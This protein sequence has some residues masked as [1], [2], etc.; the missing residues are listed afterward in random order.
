MKF[1]AITLGFVLFFAGCDKYV[2]RSKYDGLQKQLEETK[3]QLEGVQRQLNEGR[4][5]KF[6]TFSQGP[7]TWRFDPTTGE[8]CLL[9]NIEADWK[10]KATKAESCDCKDAWRELQKEQRKL[11]TP[12]ERKRYWEGTKPFIDMFCGT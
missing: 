6:S 3:K 1:T 12:E 5:H 4:N 7:R 10:R 9:L 2:E 8:T 11:T